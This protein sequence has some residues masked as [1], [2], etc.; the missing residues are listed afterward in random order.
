MVPE[1]ETD[2]KQINKKARRC[3]RYSH[4]CVWTTTDNFQRLALVLMK[5]GLDIPDPCDHMNGELVLMDG[6]FENIFPGLKGNWGMNR[7]LAM[8]LCPLPRLIS[9]FK[10]YFRQC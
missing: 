7:N 9:H 1:G 3:H 6:N 2:L 5:Y 8:S 4:V 10:W